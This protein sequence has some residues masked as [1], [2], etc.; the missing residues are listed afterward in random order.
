MAYMRMRMAVGS[1]LAV[2]V[3]LS[4]KLGGNYHDTAVTDAAFGDDAVG[5]PSHISCTALQHRHFHAVFMI[6][7]NV[8]RRL[9]QIMTVVR[10]L[11]EPLG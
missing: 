6:E 1:L 9:C 7:V 5:E 11:H 2:S 8:K 4:R 10:R 3:R